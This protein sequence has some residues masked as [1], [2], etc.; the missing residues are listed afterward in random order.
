MGPLVYLGL[1]VDLLVGIK[2]YLCF[3]YAKRIL[4]DVDFG[5]HLSDTICHFSFT[6]IDLHIIKSHYVSNAENRNL[7]A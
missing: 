1:P 4:L 3:L 5:L 7:D 6:H 2:P